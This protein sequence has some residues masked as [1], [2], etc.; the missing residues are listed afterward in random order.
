MQHSEREIRP[1]AAKPYAFAAM[2][3]DGTDT[4]GKPTLARDVLR[5]SN[6]SGSAA[7]GRE[8]DRGEAGEHAEFAHEMRLVG[9]ARVGCDRA[10]RDGRTFFEQPHGMLQAHDTCEHLGAVAYMAIEGAL[11][12]A[13]ADAHRGG[14]VADARAAARTAQ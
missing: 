13:F 8:G 10:P 9:K 3:K 7:L 12:P 6:V 4:A 2:A 1:K 11:Q 14:D 5:V